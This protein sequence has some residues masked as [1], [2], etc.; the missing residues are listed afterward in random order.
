ML[1]PGV[2]GGGGRAAAGYLLRRSGLADAP[3]DDCGGRALPLAGPSMRGND[4]TQ[5]AVLE[6]PGAGRSAPVSKSPALRADMLRRRAA[7][8]RALAPQGGVSASFWYN[9]RAA[10]YQGVRRLGLP[11][12][13]RVLVPAYCCGS[14]VDALLKAGARVELYRLRPDLSPDLDDLDRLAARGCAAIYVTHY[15]GIVQDL[16]PVLALARGA[17]AAVIEDAALC[18]YG[19]TPAGEPVGRRGDVGIFSLSKFLPVPDGGALVARQAG[20]GAAAAGRR[21]AWSAVLRKAK[22]LLRAAPAPGRGG[23]ASVPLIGPREGQGALEVGRAAWAMSPVA[24]MILR[25][26]D[27]ERTVERRRRNARRLAQLV[28]PGPRVR[29]LFATWRADAVPPHFPV[30][31]EDAAALHAHLRANGIEAVRFWRARHPSVSLKGFGFEA[32]LKE[33]VIRLPIHQDLDEAALERIGRLV[34][35]WNLRR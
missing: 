3:C 4:M 16:D 8:P 14:E 10:V 19:E 30:V 28:A 13:G 1:K 31:A 21:P 26:W 22:G 29:P 18:L 17:G 33:S 15:F 23:G 24:A 9:G 27:H 2:G 34:N 7:L 5:E 35:D 6:G 25:H 12:G 32:G 11:E 20:S